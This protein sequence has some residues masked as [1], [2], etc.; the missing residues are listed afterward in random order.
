MK[1]LLVLISITASQLFSNVAMAQENVVIFD[2]IDYVTD[3]KSG[4]VIVGAEKN[5]AK[6]ATLAFSQKSEQRARGCAA[7]AAQMLASSQKGVSLYVSSK[8][9]SNQNIVNVDYM[10]FSCSLRQ[11][12]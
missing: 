4:I 3:S 7:F 2:H 8:M 9:D 1:K 5:R 10:Y 12:D 6:I 11:I